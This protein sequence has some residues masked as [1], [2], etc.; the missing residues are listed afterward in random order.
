[1]ISVINVRGLSSGILPEVIT[2]EMMSE[3][4]YN[5]KVGGF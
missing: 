2:K 5:R 3:V 1:M 4:G